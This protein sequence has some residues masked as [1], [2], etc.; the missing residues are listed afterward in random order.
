MADLTGISIAQYKILRK[1]EGGNMGDVYKAEDTRLRRLVVIKFLS[2]QLILDPKAKE[3]F[4]RE[5]QSASALDHPNI[6]AVYEFNQTT[7]GKFYMVMPFYSGESLQNIINRGQ[8]DLNTVLE[9]ALQLCD[10]LDRAHSKGI[11]HR[12]IK[13]A[14]IFITDSGEVKLLDFGIAKLSGT[15]G[16]T[17]LYN[18][19]GTVSYM[20]P[21][22]LLGASVDNRTD[23]WSLGVVLYEMLTGTKPFTGE[24]TQTITYSILNDDP[25]N[26]LEL[27]KELPPE[28]D[29]VVRKLL[30]KQPRNRYQLGADVKED[31]NRI[32]SP[33]TNQNSSEV[34]RPNR[35]GMIWVS[36]SVIAIGLLI[37]LFLVPLGRVD[38]APNKIITVL[39]LNVDKNTGI[40]KS[41]SDGFIENV[42][43]NLASKSSLSVRPWEFSSNYKNENLDLGLLQ[44]KI[45]GD[46]FITGSLVSN[47]NEIEIRVKLLEP[48]QNALRWAGSFSASPKDMYSLQN[49]IVDQI[50]TVLLPDSKSPGEHIANGKLAPHTMA[51]DYYLKARGSYYRYTK[52]DNENAIRLYKRALQFDSNYA[53][54]EAGLADSY[55]QN[56]LRYG[57]DKI[58]LDSALVRSNRALA[59][60]ENLSDAHKSRGLVYYTRSW[61]KKS[62]EANK[63]ALKYNHSYA[64]AMANLGWSYLQ[65]GNLKLAYQNLYQAY[66]LYPTNPAILT[67]IG[68][69]HLILGDDNEAGKWLVHAYELQPD[70]QPSA[71]ILLMM[72]TMLT[73]NADSMIMDIAKKVSD[74]L[75]LIQLGDNA[76]KNKDLSESAIFYLKAMDINPQ[77]WHPFTGINI[78]T[79][80]GTIFKKLGEPDHDT[81]FEISRQ[82][83]DAAVKQ[84]SEW[85]G[86]DYDMAAYLVGTDRYNEAFQSLEKAV[87][88]GFRF[89]RYLSI[90]PHFNALQNND[91]FIQLI[92][93]IEEHNSASREMLITLN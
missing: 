20:S 85:W 88:K 74:P 33:D 86:I 30:A 92:N 15:S 22:Q 5:A 45:G 77:S 37:L 61:F 70:Y 40:E 3:R 59:I 84:G 53:E 81:L 47:G 27:E 11:I 34:K 76:F 23:I 91:R 32:L 26:I 31:L 18:I 25:G 29:S 10:A 43:F 13:P 72:M 50:K 52:E 6:C 12:D 49:R 55:A 58:W 21:E 38:D 62:I 69:V 63:N 57:E 8:P 7:D 89:S 79:S 16:E 17:S 36:A 28:L 82:Q 54:A 44:E 2:P 87:N 1:L 65:T 42:I 83:N 14:N 41:V 24:Y 73:S 9:I 51:Y 56:V 19:S 39:P 90:D 75:I 46:Y 66:Q 80:V 78:S 64:P 71:G 4:I 60:K 48:A 68:F 35:V 93:N 67:G